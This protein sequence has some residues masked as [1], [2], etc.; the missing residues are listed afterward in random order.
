MSCTRRCRRSCS[1]LQVTGE[2]GQG[3]GARRWRRLSSGWLAG[4]SSVTTHA[5]VK[6]QI[7]THGV[8]NSGSRP[9]GQYQ[10]P[11]PLHHAAPSQGIWPIRQPGKESC[12]EL[13][14][15]IAI[16]S[17]C[18]SIAQSLFVACCCHCWHCCH[19]CHSRGCCAFPFPPGAKIRMHSGSTFDW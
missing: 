9:P 4:Y 11:L 2:C 7:T 10:P 6:S 16:R 12:S 13:V 17:G 19:Y 14:R 8:A 18:M 1:R 15:F 5:L 3:E